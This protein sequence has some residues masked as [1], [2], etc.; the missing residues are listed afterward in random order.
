MARGRQ[1]IIA[2]AMHARFEERTVDRY[3]DRYT[4]TAWEELDQPSREEFLD[5]AGAI[6]TALHQHDH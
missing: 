5:Y 6:D 2:R 4:R 1:K 3:G